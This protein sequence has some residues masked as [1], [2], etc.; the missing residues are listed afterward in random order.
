MDDRHEPSPEDPCRYF[1]SQR[2]A[3][4]L[5]SFADTTLLS[6]KTR[7]S[8]VGFARKEAEETAPSVVV[9]LTSQGS[10]EEEWV[11]PKLP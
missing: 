5:V 7:E 2:G 4:W 1:V 3:Y 10:V 6:F 9:V 11:F 8:A